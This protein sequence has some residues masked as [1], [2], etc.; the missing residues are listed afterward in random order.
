MW[1]RP[2]VDRR[3]ADLIRAGISVFES[4]EAMRAYVVASLDEFAPRKIDRGGEEREADL[5]SMDRSDYYNSPEWRETRRRL[6]ARRGRR[7]QLCG[8]DGPRIVVHH[9]NY[10]AIPW[11]QESDLLVLCQRCHHEGSHCI[12]VCGSPSHCCQQHDAV[13]EARLKDRE[14]AR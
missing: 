14:V 7:C 3:V 12:P 13:A 6:I 5:L 9:N 10:D 4:Y 8:E 11:E 2:E 1:G